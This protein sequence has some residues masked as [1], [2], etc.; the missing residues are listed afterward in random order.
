MQT[1]AAKPLRLHLSETLQYNKILINSDTQ[2][3]E[4]RLSKS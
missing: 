2:N 3:E 4:L 1:Q